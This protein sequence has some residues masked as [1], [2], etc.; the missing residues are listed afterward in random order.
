MYKVL[1]VAVESQPPLKRDVASSKPYPHDTT[2]HNKSLAPCT[3][4]T[5]VEE[6]VGVAAGDPPDHFM[7]DTMAGPLS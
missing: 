5:Y 1:F 6:R 7:S 4:L 2:Q 3:P